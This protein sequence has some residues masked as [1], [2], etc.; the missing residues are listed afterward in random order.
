MISILGTKSDGK[1][2]SQKSQ[3]GTAASFLEGKSARR[4]QHFRLLTPLL[5]DSLKVPCPQPQGSPINHW[6]SIIR[7]KIKRLFLRGGY[8]IGGVG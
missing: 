2:S 3:V 8:V 5:Y 6:F 7:L 1:T 4:V